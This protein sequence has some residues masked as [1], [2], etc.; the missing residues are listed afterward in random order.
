M[1]I[2]TFSITKNRHLVSMTI[3][4]IM[5]LSIMLVDSQDNNTQHSN[6]Q[7]NDIQHN[8]IH[9][10]DTQHND[11]QHNDIQHIDIQHINK[12]PDTHLNNTQHNNIQHNNK[13]PTLL[14]SALCCY[15]YADCCG[16]II[17]M[18]LL[19]GFPFLLTGN[20]IRRPQ[21]DH[22]RGF[23]FREQPQPR[24]PGQ[25]GDPES[26]QERGRGGLAE[27]EGQVRTEVEK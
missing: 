14:C 16:A 2:L 11:T 20:S 5:I 22:P 23:R 25:P 4:S 24:N 9:H 10:N 6:T 17:G 8:F 7:H 1:S 19:F 18:C 12:K 15:F 27:E 26:G 13:K 3:L 21:E